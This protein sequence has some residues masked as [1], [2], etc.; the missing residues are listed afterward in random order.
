MAGL[1]AAKVE[2]SLTSVAEHYI[3]HFVIVEELPGLKP[4]WLGS[5]LDGLCST[6]RTFWKRKVQLLVGFIQKG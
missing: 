6:K 5:T 2:C 4:L 3:L 1:D